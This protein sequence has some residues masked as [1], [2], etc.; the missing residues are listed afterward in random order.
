MISPRAYP[1]GPARPGRVP[2]LEH[3]SMASERTVAVTGATGFVGRYVVREML[4]R[5]WTV[6]ALARSRDKAR[7]V[8]PADPALQFVGGDVLDEGVLDSLVQGAHGCINTLGIIRE[9]PGG[10]TFRK[11]HVLS[12]QAL[13]EASRRAGIQR[14]VQISAMGASEGGI[15]EYQRTKGEGERAIRESGIPWTIFRPSTIH[16]KDGEFVQMVKGWVKG[17]SQPWFFLPYFTRNVRRENVPLAATYPQPGKLAPVAVEDVAWAVGECFERPGSIG[18]IYN[19]CGP[20]VMTWPEMLVIF[21]D[22]IPGA[23]ASIQ[24][25]GIPSKQ[26]AIQATVAKKL[27]LGGLLPFDEGMALMGAEDA[28][29]EPHKARN[30]LGF[31]PIAFS[32]RLAQYAREI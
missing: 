21:R 15:T 6:R 14:L 9:R 25:L 24:P 11:I 30:H 10:Q 17:K 4:S 2:G 29:G 8:L 23:S 7:A 26:A 20:E 19:L 13:V 12:V 22:A 5:G 16:G 18:E 27:G 31:Q 28:A 3:E 32:E 1:C